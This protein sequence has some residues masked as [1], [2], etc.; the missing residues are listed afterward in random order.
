MSSGVPEGFQAALFSLPGV[1]VLGGGG[2]AGPRGARVIWPQLGHLPDVPARSSLTRSWTPQREQRNAGITTPGVSRGSDGRWV[3]WSQRFVLNGVAVQDAPGVPQGGW[4]TKR[5]PGRDKEPRS[6][7]QTGPEQPA[8]LQ[9]IVDP[10]ALDYPIQAGDVKAGET[11]SG[12]PVP[13]V[14]DNRHHPQRHTSAG[15]AAPARLRP[16][17]AGGGV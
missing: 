10:R 15:P 14:A 2:V 5:I 7:R 12:L 8:G 16:P 13:V 9:G 17:S 1:G 6:P 4:P 3:F 11:W